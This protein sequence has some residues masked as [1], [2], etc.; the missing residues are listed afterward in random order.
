LA[1]EQSGLSDDEHT[2]Q[3]AQFLVDQQQL[4]GTWR[5]WGVT[6][7]GGADLVECESELSNVAIPLMA[8]AKWGLSNRASEE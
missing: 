4:S 3:A 7:K 1:L 2:Q 8:L 5:V 6:P